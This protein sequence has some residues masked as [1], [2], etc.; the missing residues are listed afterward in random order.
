MDAASLRLLANS[1]ALDEISNGDDGS[2][3]ERR[4][5]MAG[6]QGGLVKDGVTRKAVLFIVYQTERHGPRNGFRVALV[7]EGARVDEARERLKVVVEEN[8]E[9]LTVIGPR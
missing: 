8:A 3:I 4:I 7:L 9:E 1:G 2:G 6:S 5:L